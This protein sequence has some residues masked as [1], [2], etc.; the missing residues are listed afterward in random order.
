[1]TVDLSSEGRMGLASQE[2]AGEGGTGL[3]P[4]HITSFA[5]SLAA[6]VGLGAQWVWGHPASEL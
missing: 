3:V 5:L 4:S 6:P 1:M 2:V